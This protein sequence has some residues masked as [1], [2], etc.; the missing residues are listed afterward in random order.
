M[1]SG[2]LL[3]LVISAIC[4]AMLLFSGL[5]AAGADLRSAP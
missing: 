4:L 2:H 3:V 1:T 5:A